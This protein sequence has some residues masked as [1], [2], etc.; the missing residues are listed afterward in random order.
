MR[1]R[2]RST[3][4]RVLIVGAG[5]AGVSAAEELRQLGFAGQIVLLGDERDAPYDRPACSKGLLT[6]QLRP[7]DAAL[8][9]SDGLQVHWRL[10]RRA[11]SLDPV[12]RVVCTDTDEAYSYDGLVIATGADVVPPR[13]WPLGEPG[14]HVLHGLGDAWALRQ[15]LRHA[16]RVAVVGAGLSGCETACAVRSLA[17][18]CVLI[19]SSPAVMTRALGT[20]VG[21]FLT[22]QLARDGVALH[23]GRRLEQLTR[24]RDGWRLWLD[25]G[26][27]LEADIVVA[28]T[29]ER[30]DTGWLGCARGLDLTDGVRCDESLRVLGADDVVAAGTVARWPNPRYGPT[31]RRCGQW[32]AALEQGRAAARTLLAGDDPA[33]PV[34]LLPRFWSYQFG[35]RIQACGELPADAE[36]GVAQRRPGRRDLLRSGVLVSYAQ[37]DRL[38]GLV[39]VNAP[40]AFNAITRSLL[41]TAQPMLS[42]TRSRLAAVS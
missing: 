40:S 13:G 38:V 21:G 3:H 2:R 16:R 1:H 6:G 7:R 9:M 11:V 32:I 42:A 33:A 15:N 39:A 35:L 31:P 25:N 26:T 23:L 24:Y 19:D 36:I 22:G 5:R 4:D 29:G 30:P 18:E 14:L 27:E 20:V 10:G 37:Q 17:R 28:T 12:A 41:A 34:A 8:T